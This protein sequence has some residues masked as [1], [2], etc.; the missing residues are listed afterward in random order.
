MIVIKPNYS[1][2]KIRIWRC[3]GTLQVGVSPY[4][5]ALNIF[6]LC[7]SMKVFHGEKVRTQAKI[8]ELV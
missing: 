7:V 6:E 1:S 3:I 8:T 4:K 2:A 5:R